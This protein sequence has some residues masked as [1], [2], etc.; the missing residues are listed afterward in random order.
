[1][2]LSLVYVIVYENPRYVRIANELGRT[3]DP[4]QRLPAAMVGGV[5]NVI[6]LAWFTGTNGPDVFWLVPI[7][8][9]APFGAGM[10]LIFLALQN[11]SSCAGIARRSTQSQLTSVRHL[12]PPSHALLTFTTP[13]LPTFLSGVPR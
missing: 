10:V 8:A 1:M 11:V 5:L 12:P 6:G 9:S 7:M 2:I 3:P 4:E 13:F